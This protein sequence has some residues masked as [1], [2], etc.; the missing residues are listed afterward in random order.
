MGLKTM[1]TMT[2]N[3][4]FKRAFFLGFA[5]VLGVDFARKFGNKEDENK[6]I[7]NSLGAMDDKPWDESKHKRDKDGKFAKEGHSRV[8]S[9]L[10]AYKKEG[11]NKHAEGDEPKSRYLKSLP[12]LK[13]TDAKAINEATKP[14]SKAKKIDSETIS[15]VDANTLIYRRERRYEGKRREGE[16]EYVWEYKGK[17]LDDKRAMELEKAMSALKLS[18]V[19]SSLTSDVVV[20]SDFAVCDGQIAQG[21]MKG[22]KNGFTAYA[23]TTRY[24]REK[25]KHA[26][27]EKLVGTLPKFI[28]Q[29][30]KDIEAGKPEAVLTYFIHQTLARAGSKS[31]TDNDTYG[32]ST[33]RPE[34]FKIDEEGN[35]ICKFPAKNAWWIL[36]IKDKFLKNW[37]SKKLKTA[38]AGKPLFGVSY[39]KLGD[40]LKTT[41]EKIGLKGDDVFKAHDFRR[42]TATQKASDYM[43]AKIKEDKSILKDDKKYQRACAEAINYAANALCDSSKVVFDKYIAPQVLFKQRPE[44]ADAYLRMHTGV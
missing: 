2:K 22:E 39:D 27:T 35:L 32:A 11:D 20:R 16:P 25:T 41:S 9:T 33:L 4:E 29:V 37:I 30:G 42:V 40:Y 19:L 36:D 26:K 13:L 23:P 24:T 10:H 15:G 14:F 38:E 44:L 3:D 8:E 1:N 17:K 34:H 28:E 5:F 12:K 21:K 43:D 6:F 7:I 31:K 18:N